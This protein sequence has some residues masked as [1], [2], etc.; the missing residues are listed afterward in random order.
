MDKSTILAKQREHES[1]LKAAGIG[2][3]FLHGS[4]ARGTAVHEI[5]DVDV[6]A[7]FS[8]GRRLSL[9]DIVA[10]ENR[11]ADVLG[12]RVDLSPAKG[13]KEPVAAKASRQA[14]L[15]F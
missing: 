4:Y 5:S 12:A 14:V 2:H 7:E 3:L 11:L 1:E 9:L 6:I 8:P 15:A 13:L 10:L